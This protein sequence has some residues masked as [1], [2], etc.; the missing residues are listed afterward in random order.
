MR[1]DEPVRDR[2]EQRLT[3]EYITARALAESATLAEAT[4]RILT[5]IC[6]ALDWEYAGLWNVDRDT[7]CLRC[8]ETCHQPGAEFPEFEAVSRRTTFPPGIGLPGRVWAS[9]QPAWIPD[10]VHDR[11][12]PRA[13]IADKEGLHAAFGFPILLRGQTRG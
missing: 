7:N 6:E 5:A 3:A 11:N 8:V 10:V 12:F 9:G 1:D 13:P 2:A 4:P